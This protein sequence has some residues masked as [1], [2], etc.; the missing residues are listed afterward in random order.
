MPTGLLIRKN[1]NKN[2][3]SLESFCF[4]D[5]LSLMKFGVFFG[6]F[7]L[8][9]ALSVFTVSASASESEW[10]LEGNSSWR[11]TSCPA[12]TESK[13][14]IIV[15]SSS[16]SPTA[17]QKTSFQASIKRQLEYLQRTSFFSIILN[18]FISQVAIVPILMVLFSR[19]AWY[20]IRIKLKGYFFCGVF[21]LYC[22]PAFVVISLA[23]WAQGT[24]IEY[25]E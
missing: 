20:W 6:C 4:L 19:T 9:V 17:P 13:V 21:I 16:P 3:H 1:L 8:F 25:S 12:P 2:S 14:S 22:L 15:E 11:D 23:C 24:M 10:D 5:S 18:I 7:V